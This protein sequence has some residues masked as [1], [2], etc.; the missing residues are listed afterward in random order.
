MYDR[1]SDHLRT[2]S[3][4]YYVSAGLSVFGILALIFYFVIFG[5]FFAGV[6]A[7]ANAPQGIAAVGAFVMVIGVIIFALMCT[8]TYL[9][10]YC[11]RCLNE[12]KHYIFCMIMAGLHCLSFPLGTA[13]GIFTFVVLGRE[14]VKQSFESNRIAS[15]VRY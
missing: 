5:L 11:G 12:R 4:L 8:M 9:T 14:S 10:Y 1:D 15:E 3:I 13:L 7:E 6:S 2:L